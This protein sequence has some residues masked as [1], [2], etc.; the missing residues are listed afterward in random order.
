[1]KRLVYVLIFATILLVATLGGCARNSLVD[2]IKL[3]KIK[4]STT[5]VRQLRVAIH[6]PKYFRLR[7]PGAVMTMTLDKT[8]SK[9]AQHE[10]FLL[11]S[12]PAS[13]EL[14]KLALAEGPEGR[15]FAFRIRPD[16]VAR[17]EHI[18][19]QSR[20]NA[21]GGRRS[22]SLSVT[23]RLCRTKRRLPDKVPFSAYL[24]AQET[25]EYVA[26][27]RDVDLMAETDFKTANQR[28]PFCGGHTERERD[29]PDIS[30]A[31]FDQIRQDQGRAL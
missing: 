8:H 20:Q 31:F 27:A 7:K 2:A 23:A 21:P 26:L 15:F 18:R 19:S 11:Q 6:V 13:P 3:N 14:K 4:F 17:F 22:G 9:P 24:K 25:G 5:N 1:M 12:V 10:R 16:D 30:K 28:T 29:R